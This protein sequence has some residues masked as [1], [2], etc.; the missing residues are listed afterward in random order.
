MMMAS[1]TGEKSVPVSTTISPVTQTAEVEVNR[2]TKRLFQEPSAVEKGSNKSSVPTAITIKKPK[3]M[4][5]DTVICIDLAANRGLE[6]QTL[7]FHELALQTT[8]PMA[9]N[10]G[11]TYD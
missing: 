4:V 8:M 3:Q 5:R 11:D 1:P 9:R 2:A 10:A 6:Q 7:Y